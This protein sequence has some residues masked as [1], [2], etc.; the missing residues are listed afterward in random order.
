MRRILFALLLSPVLA[1]AQFDPRISR[2]GNAGFNWLG[3]LTTHI[4]ELTTSTS[5]TMLGLGEIFLA[6]IAALTAVQMIMRWQLSVMN[7]WHHAHGL[8]IG[9]L[10][11]LLLKVLAAQ[12]M[13]STYPWFH[14]LFP[15][16]FQ[17][18]TQQ[19]D[20]KMV[21]AFIDHMQVFSMN[22][23]MPSPL[24]I[25]GVLV[26]FG[27]IGLIAV[28]QLALF[29]INAVGFAAV[30]IFTIVGPLMIPFV[31]TKRWDGRFW[32]WV[33]VMCVYSSYRFLAACFSFVFANTFM[34]FFTK[35]LAGD[36]SIGN[37]FALFVTFFPLSIAF[38]WLMFMIPS[39]ASQLFGGVG[40]MGQGFANDVKAFVTGRI[41]R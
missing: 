13:L 27:T 9:E 19:V 16:L 34:V 25:P 39:I 36:Y 4:D 2:I 37:L 15:L 3:D 10:Y 17:Q 38:L 21:K 12:A 6:F 24:N 41:G 31:V 1:S 40:A 7:L 23:E 5:G 18:L 8:H 11:W 14:R 32:M 30:G 29:A 20:M 26:V 22:L 35:A 28:T 33:D